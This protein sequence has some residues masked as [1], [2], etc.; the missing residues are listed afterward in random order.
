MPSKKPLLTNPPIINQPEE[1]KI[2]VPFWLSLLIIVLIALIGAA[3]I[4]LTYQ[5]PLPTNK[6]ETAP[7]KNIPATVHSFVGKITEVGADYLALEAAADRNYLL[8]NSALV[9]KLSSQTE[10]K[11]IIIPQKI[12]GNAEND[13]IQTQNINKNELKV[14]QTVV[15]YSRDNL[16]NQTTFTA[17][18]IE[19]Q[20]IK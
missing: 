14:G 18:R 16:K 20:V 12:T 1:N 9:I 5:K 17:D 15:V 2:Y 19:L 3:V 10:F 8:Q 7:S 6:L 4:L 11:K 13:Q